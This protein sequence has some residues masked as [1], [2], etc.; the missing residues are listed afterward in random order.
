MKI[1][2]YGAKGQVGS[3]VL[4]ELLKQGH[5]VFAGT[6][7]PEEGKKINGLTWVFADATKPK[8]GLGILSKVDS[9]FFLT[10]PGLMNQFEILQPWFEKAKLEKLKKLVL[11]T[12]M[13]VEFAP[14][15]VPMRKAEL[16]LKELGV[17]FNIIRPNWFMQNFHTYWISGIL[18]T[19]NILFPAGA[20]K[21]SFIDVRDISAVATVL[22]TS[23]QFDS[24]EFTLTGSESLTHEEVAEKISHA[25]GKKIGYK[26]ISSEEFRQG[27]IGAGLPEDYA[28]FM[29]MIANSL[30]EGQAA[31]IFPSVKEITG[32]SPIHFTEYAN[33]YKKAWLV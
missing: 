29:V 13:G 25:T 5:E 17:P 21:T 32:K 9:A 28:G 11:M 18:S 33:A 23:S 26:D 6:R 2:I 12:A 3:G 24:Q 15:E 16:V 27:L 10:P 22:L 14:A 1:F 20:A 31:P 30:K 7:K 8:E 19:G 4:E